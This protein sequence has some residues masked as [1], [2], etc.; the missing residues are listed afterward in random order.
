MTQIDG[1]VYSKT[2]VCSSKTVNF[3]HQ[4]RRF[5]PFIS[6]NSKTAIHVLSSRHRNNQVAKG[7]KVASFPCKKFRA[8]FNTLH[9]PFTFFNRLRALKNVVTTRI[10]LN[11]SQGGLAQ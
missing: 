1:L 10:I 5:T 7:L 6:Q 2:T 9:S 4:N 3:R 8:R 11:G